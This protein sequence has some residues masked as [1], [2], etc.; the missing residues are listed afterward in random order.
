MPTDLID[1][2]HLIGDHFHWW[3]KYRSKLW[4]EEWPTLFIALL[5]YK[6]RDSWFLPKIVSEQTDIVIE[7][8]PRSANSFSAKAFRSAQTQE[9][10]VADHTHSYAQVIRGVQLGKP[11]ILLIRHPYE[12]ILSLKALE[13]ELSDGRGPLRDPIWDIRYYT[14]FYQRTLAY[15][16]NIVPAFFE[17]VLEDFGRFIDRVN[18][19]FDTAFDAFEHTKEQVQ[20]LFDRHGVHMSPSTTRDRYKEQVKELLAQRRYK[21]GLAKAEAIYLAWQDSAKPKTQ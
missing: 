15:Q 13:L 17:D 9:L 4:L 10:R 11:V 20:A 18:D 7:G 3:L 19:R 12:A 16:Q 14:R 6:H 21:A 2:E 1:Q 5:R 8:F